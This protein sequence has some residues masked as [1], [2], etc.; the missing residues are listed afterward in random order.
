[1]W[2]KKIIDALGKGN[3]DACDVYA[4][5]WVMNHQDE[6][7]SFKKRLQSDTSAY[8]EA[9]MFVWNL[10]SERTHKKLYLLAN[11]EKLSELFRCE[12]IEK[13]DLFTSN[14]VD[15]ITNY[16]EDN[17]LYWNYKSGTI[18][19]TN[20]EP[21]L[22]SVFRWSKRKA[23]IIY[24]HL[25]AIYQSYIDEIICK[26]A[27]K[28]ISL[29]GYDDYRYMAEIR[30]ILFDFYSVMFISCLP[31]YIASVKDALKK[32]IPPLMTYVYYY[33]HFDKGSTQNASFVLSQFYN[34]ESGPQML[35]LIEA[36][37]DFLGKNDFEDNLA[38]NK[39]WKNTID[40]ALSESQKGDKARLFA[41]LSQYRSKA[42]NKRSR[43]KSLEEMLSKNCDIPKTI[44]LIFFYLSSYSNDEEYIAILFWALS[45]T[46]FVDKEEKPKVFMDALNYELNVKMDYSLVYKKLRLLH[47]VLEKNR[48]S[49]SNL[50]SKYYEVFGDNGEWTQRFKELQKGF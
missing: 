49:N 29:N 36:L 15:I 33:I 12:D 11:T 13:I 40:D 5:K 48:T 27:S 17:A 6:Y 35:T 8:I 39:D 23:V 47:A 31:E 19:T 37:V 34:K 16:I 20:S 44:Q 42:G 9:L 43:G 46:G 50:K 26:V 32:G 18:G 14:D 1:M 25:S 38:T 41:T 3:V 45:N 2:W 10:A 28:I 24:N 30:S 21:N 4:S 22:K 7:N